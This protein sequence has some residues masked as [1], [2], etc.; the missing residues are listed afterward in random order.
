MPRA[1]FEEL[2]HARLARGEEPLANPRNTAAGTLKMIDADSVAQRLLDF[3]PYALKT[4]NLKTHEEGI[5]LLEQWGFTTSPTY[6]KCSTTEEVIAY[7]NYWETNKCNLP[8]DIDGIVIKVNALEQQDQLG[9]TAKAHGGLLPT[10]ISQRVWHDA[11]KGVYQ[12]GRTGAVT[13]VAHLKPVLLAGTTVKRASLY[14]AQ[15]ITRL[16]LHLEDTVFVEK[17]GDIIPKITAIDITNENQ[18]VNL[19]SSLLTVPSVVRPWYNTE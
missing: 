6:Q 18:G 12:V 5:H 10:S 8:V 4:E 14:N 13:P 11:R 17:G 3:Y 9:Y 2:N 15:E 19:L 1:Y 7:I 16:N